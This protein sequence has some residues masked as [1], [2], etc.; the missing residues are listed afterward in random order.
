MEKSRIRDK[1]PGSATLDIAF[2]YGSLSRSIKENRK[3]TESAVFV[4]VLMGSTWLFH[5]LPALSVT[6]PDPNK[7]ALFWAVLRSRE[8]RSRNYELRLRL[9][10]IYHR[11]E[12]IL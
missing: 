9:L 10:S 5:M 1:H 8:P 4:P 3:G 2:G 12:E 6:D 11:L 7:T